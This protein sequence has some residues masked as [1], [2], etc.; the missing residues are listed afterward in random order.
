MVHCLRE[1]ALF[2]FSFVAVFLA[3][4]SFKCTNNFIIFA[5]DGSSFQGNQWTKYIA[6]PKIQRPNPCLLMFASV[7]GFH[8]LLSTQ[9]TDDLTLEWSRESM[10][11]PLSHIYAKTPFCCIKTI[12]NNTLNH[13]HIVFDWLSKHDTYFQHS[14][15]IDKCSCK[16]VNTLLCY[17]TQ[18][19]FTTGQNEF[20]E[21]FWCF[22]GQL[23][24]FGELSVQHHLCLYNCV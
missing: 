5:I 13:W 10:F 23:P 21:F 1:R 24:N 20:V 8:L 18:L 12:A 11:H 22:P 19:Q 3:I 9:L 16:M 4:S 17:P 14:F 6:H 15:L 7:D 2:S